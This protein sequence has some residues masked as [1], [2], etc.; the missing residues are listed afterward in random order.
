MHD[1]SI[2]LAVCIAS[3]VT[4]PTSWRSTATAVLDRICDHTPVLAASLTSFDPMTGRHTVLASTGYEQDVLDFLRSPAFLQDDVGYQHLVRCPD[5]GPLCWRD[6]PV[7]YGQSPSAVRVFRPAGYAGGATARLVTSDGRYTGD[8]HLSSD[9]PDRPTPDVLASLRSVVAVMAMVTDVTRRLGDLL[10][11]VDEEAGA[12]VVTDDAGVVPVPGR[13]TPSFLAE[14]PDVVRCVQGWRTRGRPA[15][16]ALFYVPRGSAGL[17]VELIA[18]PAGSLVIEHV[19]QPR[20][21]LSTREVEV[22]TLVSDGML[23]VSI[24]RRLDISE[25]TVAHHVEHVLG[26]LGVGNRTA[27]ARVAVED[28]L[29]L[30]PGSSGPI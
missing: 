16:R 9:D 17:R 11:Y 8:L 23:N 15:D 28:G 21:G 26:K 27:A 18:V 30:L 20:H 6:V 1:S 25:R 29:R 7:D 12:A 19:A 3:A 13:T 22:L 10:S 4:G 2:P 5:R 14:R 24:A